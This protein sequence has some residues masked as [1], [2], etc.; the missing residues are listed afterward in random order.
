MP[1]KKLSKEFLEPAIASS[2]SFSEAMRKCGYTSVTGGS[3]SH[4]SKT[5]RKLGI[6]TSHL[7]GQAR[8]RGQKASNKKSASDYL[9]YHANG[10]R[11]RCACLVRSLL[12][13]GRDHRCFLCGIS[14]WQGKRLVL[15]IEHKD[16]DFQNDREDNLEFICPNC[17]SQTDTYCRSKESLGKEKVKK[18]QRI[19]AVP[20]PKKPRPRKVE[21]P[22]LEELRLL[23]KEM[24]MTKI[25]EKYG[26]SDNAVRKWFRK[27]GSEIP[28][29]K[30]A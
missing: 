21:W 24:S 4:F 3:H 8:N 26:I 13:I 27:Y 16:G 10:E 19:P 25:G 17:H 14:D 28:K 6:D 18:K 11:Q 23:S 15:E 29:C 1:N 30:R 2:L 5:V 9:V 7:L 12:E 22:S 20:R